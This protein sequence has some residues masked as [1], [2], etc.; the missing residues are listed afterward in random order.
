MYCLHCKSKLR[1]FRKNKDWENRQYHRVC[2]IKIQNSFLY[3]YEEE[4]DEEIDP[5]EVLERVRNMT[6]I[7]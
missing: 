1:P 2:F 4:M 5:H 3:E 7:D 6:T